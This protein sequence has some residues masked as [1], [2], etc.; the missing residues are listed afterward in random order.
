V[1]IIIII[2][3]QLLR[4]LIVLITIDIKASQEESFDLNRSDTTNVTDKPLLKSV[5]KTVGLLDSAFLLLE[6]FLLLFL[7]LGVWNSLE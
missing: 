6:A 1:K 4:S 3:K 5:L 7:H 2:I